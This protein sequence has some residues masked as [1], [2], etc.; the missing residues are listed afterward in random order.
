MQAIT[1]DQVFDVVDRIY[2]ARTGKS[3]AGPDTGTGTGPV[4]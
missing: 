2:R 3:A 1:V 4:A